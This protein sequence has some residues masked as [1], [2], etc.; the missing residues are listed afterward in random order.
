M[1]AVVAP[2]SVYTV[3]ASWFTLAAPFN[4]I[5]G[6]ILSSTV[7]VAVPVAETFEGFVTVS[8]TV[9]APISAHV[10]VVLSNT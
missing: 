10:N 7:T 4:V 5:L 1:S 3:K 8:V 2:K 6:A 9:C